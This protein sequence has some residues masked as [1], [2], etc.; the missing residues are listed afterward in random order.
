[1]VGRG[2][3]AEPD[4]QQPGRVRVGE[5]HLD[6]L[7]GGARRRRALEV[8]ERVDGVPGGAEQGV[9]TGAEEVARLGEVVACV[10]AVP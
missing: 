2:A 6:D 8:R 10:V 3:R 7:T 1:V 4:E 9:G 5:R